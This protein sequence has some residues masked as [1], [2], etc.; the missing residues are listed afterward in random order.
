MF[1]CIVGERSPRQAD[2]S[3]FTVMFYVGVISM[4]FALI[5]MASIGIVAIKTKKCGKQ[6][7]IFKFIVKQVCLHKSSPV[8]DILQL[9]TRYFMKRY[10]SLC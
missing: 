10:N 8:F 3:S 2:N 4:A 6:I 1:L 5:C 9:Q 7:N